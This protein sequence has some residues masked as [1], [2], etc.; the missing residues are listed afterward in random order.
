[1]NSSRLVDAEGPEGQ[2]LA[3]L[4]VDEEDLG[5]QDHAV[6]SGESLRDVLLEMSHLEGEAAVRSRSAAPQVSEA[7]LTAS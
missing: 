6:A 2:R 4:G 1:M 7:E 5:V 3:G